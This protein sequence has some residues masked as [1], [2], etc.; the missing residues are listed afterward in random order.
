MKK[1]TIIIDKKNSFLD[2]E[3]ANIYVWLSFL[4]TQ[5]TDNY[6]QNNILTFFSI[7]TCYFLLLTSILYLIKFIKNRK[8]ISY[9]RNVSNEDV[10]YIEC[11]INKETNELKKFIIKNKQE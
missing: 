7:L 5:I 1:T 8:N 10:D 6:I 2:L 9:Y 4:L 3:K 11:V